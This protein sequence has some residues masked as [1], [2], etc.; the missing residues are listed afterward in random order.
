MKGKIFTQADAS[1]TLPLVRRIV[2]DVKACSKLIER[3]ERH[4][5]HP[6]V[7]GGVAHEPTASEV[8]VIHEKIRSLRERIKLCHTELE[9]LGWFLVDGRAGLAH[10]YGEIGGQIVYLSWRL[11][12]N[13][14]NFWHATDKSHV[15]RKKIDGGERVTEGA[16]GR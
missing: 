12:E 6:D 10:C 15:E 13:G 8:S 1:R 5:S 16:S 4:L 11:G 2:L 14:V 7:I 3:H 9:Q